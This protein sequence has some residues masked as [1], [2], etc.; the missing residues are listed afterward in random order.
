[1]EKQVYNPF[2]PLWEYIPDGEPHKFDGRIYVYG[3]HDKFGGKTFCMNDY[4]CWS[5]PEDDLSDWRYEGVIWR[6]DQDPMNKN[7]KT[8][9]LSECH[10]EL[11]YAQV[12][13]FQKVIVIFAPR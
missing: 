8:P 3:S 4:V 11:A 13:F 1:M 5:A 6:K 12:Q 9:I 7:G 2:L 10:I